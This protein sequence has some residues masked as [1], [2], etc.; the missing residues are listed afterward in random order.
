MSSS[1]DAVEALLWFRT[2]YF[3]L[4][5]AFLIN[6][7]L[8]YVIWTS[9]SLHKPL[10]IFMICI[11]ICANVTI[12]FEIIFKTDFHNLLPFKYRSCKLLRF[13]N[14][15]TWIFKP[16]LIS[17]MFIVILVRPDI[18]KRITK[19]I[20]AALGIVSVML[21]VPAGIAA[22]IVPY[23]NSTYCI[24]GLYSH[25]YIMSLT[26]GLEIVLPL[27]LLI[28]YFAITLT[29]NRCRKLIQKSQMTKLMLAILMIYLVCCTPLTIDRFFDLHFNV[30]WFR[31]STNYVHFLNFEITLACISLAYKPI[32]FYFTNGEFQ[33]A[34]NQL[35]KRENSQVMSFEN[36]MCDDENVLCHYIDSFES[37]EE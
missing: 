2:F 16:T 9:K 22:K 8:I 3:L 18:S 13:F 4:F 26:I 6:S 23:Q 32:L 31:G 29:G 19:M 24:S 1:E 10:F 27:I 36:Q 20:I 28:G 35:F 12:S 7:I 15:A 14:S 37:F 33:E 30:D 21:A 17:T 34:L 5:S 25:P 11:A